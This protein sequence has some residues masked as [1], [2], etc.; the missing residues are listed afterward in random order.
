L[1]DR[2]SQDL[3]ESAPAIEQTRPNTGDAA[4]ADESTP[5]GTDA[6]LARK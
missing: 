6:S 5:P 2:D 1:Q 4:R 3:I